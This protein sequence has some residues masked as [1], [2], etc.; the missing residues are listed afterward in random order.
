[1]EG[2]LTRHSSC[3]ENN[4]RHNNGKSEAKLEKDTNISTWYLFRNLFVFIV[5]FQDRRGGFR[6]NEINTPSAADKVRRVWTSV[7][8]F[9]TQG[10]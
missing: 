3:S 5:C 1:M 9:K 6:G 8:G 7:G 10:T 2:A 4:R